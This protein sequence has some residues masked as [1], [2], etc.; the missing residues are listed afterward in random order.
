MMPPM[1]AI[2]LPS[3]ENRGLAICRAGLCTGLISPDATAM[4]KSCAIHQLLS[5]LPFDAV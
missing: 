2:C 4:V 1:K 5:P 3:G